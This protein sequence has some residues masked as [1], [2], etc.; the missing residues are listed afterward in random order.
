M[1]SFSSRRNYLRNSHPGQSMMLV[2]AALG[3][4]GGHPWASKG[5]D[6][7]RWLLGPR[8]RRCNALQWS[9]SCSSVA[10]LQSRRTGCSSLVPAVP[11]LSLLPRNPR[12]H[13]ERSLVCP[14]LAYFRDLTGTPTP[15]YKSCKATQCQSHPNQT[16][17]TQC[18]ANPATFPSSRYRGGWKN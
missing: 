8:D 13:T 2:E 12:T 9:C 10:A 6:P 14:D 15:P 16:K 18:Q 17:P 5:W 11:P 4:S 7:L 3:G 1:E